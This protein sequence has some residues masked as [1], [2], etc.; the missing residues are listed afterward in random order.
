M[1]MD[2]KSK[3]VIDRLRS[4]R[5][6]KKI[7]QLDLSM[8]AGI[9]QS[10]LA[11]VETYKKA[12]TIITIVKLCD[13]LNIRISMIFEEKDYDKEEKKKEIIELIQKYL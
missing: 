7:S 3:A 8:K 2:E 4:L 9:S 13:A 5:I 1:K 11:Q 10:F 12:P 6:E